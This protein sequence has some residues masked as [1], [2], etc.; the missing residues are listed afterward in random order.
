VR[1]VLDLRPVGRPG[2]SELLFEKFVAGRETRLIVF[3]VSLVTL[4]VC[5]PVGA[6]R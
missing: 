5:D 6:R 3:C 4:T 1:G 2:A